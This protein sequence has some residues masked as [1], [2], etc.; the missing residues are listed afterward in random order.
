MAS[1]EIGIIGLPNVGKTSVFNALTNAGAEVTSYAATSF[2]KNVGIAAVPDARLDELAVLLSSRETIYATVQVSDVSGLA[3]GSGKGGG[4][5][6]E[7]LGTL[8]TV[9]ALVHVVR[10]F[11]DEDV[12]HVD[13]RVDPLADAEAVDLELLLADHAIVERRIDRLAKAGRTGDK[14]AIAEGALLERLLAHLDGGEPARSFAEIIPTGIDLLTTKPLLFVANTS[15]SGDPEAVAALRGYAGE[16]EVVP[17]AAK[18]EAELAELD[19]PEERSAFL[20]EI[21]QS[22]PSMP[23]VARAAFRLLHLIQ[24]FTIGPKEARAWPLR[25]GSSAVEAAGKIHS[26]I[27]RGFIR[28]EVISTTDMLACKTNAEAVKRGVMRVEGRDYVIADGDIVNVRFN[29]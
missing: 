28:A 21:G 10:T 17:V 29:I 13:G 16:I 9:D 19:D 7:F 23:R 4:L 15:E 3:R 8:R 11:P 12:F 22:E 1:L 5:G 6:G 14:A 24:F 20:A 25:A 26:D 2:S 27:A 18:F